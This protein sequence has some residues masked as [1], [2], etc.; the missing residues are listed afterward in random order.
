LGN[1]DVFLNGGELLAT[2]TETINTSM[3]LDPTSTI[4]AATGQTLTLEGSAQLSGPATLAFGTPGEDGTILW[5]PSTFQ[6]L[7]ASPYNLDV[8][9]GD[10]VFGNYDEGFA[11]LSSAWSSADIEAGATLDLAGVPTSFSS[12]AGGGTLTASST[13]LVTIAGGQFTGNLTGYINLNITGQV[14]L[15]GSSTLGGIEIGNGGAFTSLTDEPGGF[16]DLDTNSDISATSTSAYFVNDGTVLRNGMAGSSIVSVPFLNYGTM[17]IT[18]GSVTFTGGFFNSGTVVGR[19]TTNGDGSVTWTP[20]PAANDFNSDAKA[21]I[22][23]QNA[24]GDVALWNSNSGSE[25]FTGQDLGVRGS[26]WQ[27]AGTGVFN[28]ASEASILWRS[29]SGDTELW[30]PN[31]SGG[32]ASQDL[33]VVPTSWQVGGTGNFT[34]AGEGILW[35]NSN[36]DTV[37]WNPNGS[38]G[39]VGEDLGIVPAG[40]QIAGTGDFAGNGEDSILWRNANGDTLLWNPNGSGGFVGEDLGVVGSGWQIAGTGDFTG[41]GEDSILW[42]NTSGDTLLWNP[43]GSGGFTGE[44]LGVVPASW[45][46]AGT[47]DFTGTGED[48]ILWRNT[49]GDTF[50]W[51]PNGSGGFTGQDLGIVSTSWSVHKIFA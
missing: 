9:A 19:L 7:G 4:A 20:G 16:I 30:N 51:N 37:I 3:V 36:G 38:G 21:D 45:Q 44:N 32:F 25:S 31:G 34:G 18:T 12:L 1:G 17:R 15:A 27:I 28:G 49:S 13:S 26:G 6:V 43:N 47:G 2:T 41:T 11:A 24:N 42:R 10:L 40:W 14:A 39:F 50:L 5:A 35:R 23:W 48:S 22:L 46:I 29:A 8:R 33:G